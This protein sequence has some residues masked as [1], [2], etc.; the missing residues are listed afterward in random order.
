MFAGG[1]GLIFFQARKPR[2]K[3][4]FIALLC[5]FGERIGFAKKALDHVL[6]GFESLPGLIFIG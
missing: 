4:H 2:T 1:L 3:E 6:R 5:A